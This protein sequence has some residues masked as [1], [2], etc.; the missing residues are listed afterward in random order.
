MRPLDDDTNQAIFNGLQVFKLSDELHTIEYLKENIVGVYI[1]SLAFIQ[2]WEESKKKGNDWFDVAL[3]LK[4]KNDVIRKYKFPRS[5]K[6]RTELEKKFKKK[7]VKK[8]KKITIGLRMN[9]IL[10]E[11]IK[12]KKIGI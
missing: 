1:V 8:Q 9:S 12:P 5:K 11:F 3:Y 10:A 4:D 7:K 6:I 2:F